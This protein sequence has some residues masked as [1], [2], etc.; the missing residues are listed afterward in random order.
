[1]ER[2]ATERGNTL[3]IA[4]ALVTGM[5]V[6]SLGA[7]KFLRQQA[8]A[9]AELRFAGYPTAQALYAAEK[10]INALMYQ[11]NIK[12]VRDAIEIPPPATWERTIAYP[13]VTVTQRVGYRIVALDP[14]TPGI[15]R[16]EVTG[17]AVPVG[18]NTGWTPIT[19]TLRFDVASGSAWV[20]QRYEQK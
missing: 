20:L 8:S 15:F 11:N 3:L 2:H 14:V 1:M 6:L 7:A 9:G 17:E 4:T 16:Y 12:P 5:T 18:G 10:G 13:V 19:R